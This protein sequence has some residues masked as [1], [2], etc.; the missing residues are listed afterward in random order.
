MNQYICGQEVNLAVVF[1]FSVDTQPVDPAAVSAEVLLPDGTTT[2]LTP[3]IVH[4]GVG[5]Y[6]VLFVPT[7][8]GLHQYRFSGAGGINAA[9]EGAFLAQ[10]VFP[11]T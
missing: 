6:S 3:D 5:Q 4:S 11:S 2:D 10:T 7:L 9:A 1:S 8:N